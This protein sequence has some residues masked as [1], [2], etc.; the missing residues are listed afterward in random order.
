MGSY[1]K[2][3]Y[4]II[5]HGNPESERRWRLEGTVTS[6]KPGHLVKGGTSGDD[7]IEV[8]GNGEQPTGYLGYEDAGV[9]GLDHTIDT[10]YAVDDYPP[11]HTLPGI[12]C[13]LKVAA[14]QGAITRG[15]TYFI[16]AANGEIKKQTAAKETPCAYAEESVA[17]HVTAARRMVR[18]IKG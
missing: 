1:R 10:A 18:W 4:G 5:I 8:C 16:P 13:Q 6:A 7:Y 11:V 15:S 3:D 14:S 17:S 9:E 12:V 2:T